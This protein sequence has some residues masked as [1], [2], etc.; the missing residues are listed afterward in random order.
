MNNELLKG[1]VEQINLEMQSAYIYLGMSS[2]LNEVD[3]PGFSQWMMAQA[4]EEMEHGMRIY[5]FLQE[6][7]EHIELFAFEEVSVNYDG[8]LHVFEE[9]LQHEKFVSAAIDKLMNLAHD[10]RDFSAIGML[11]WFVDEQVEEEDNFNGAIAQIKLSGGKGS[12][13]LMLDRGFGKREG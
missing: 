7:G 10:V 11:Q 9:S 12:P 4:H 2:Y 8:V 13:M 6:R 5:K 3:L 1:L